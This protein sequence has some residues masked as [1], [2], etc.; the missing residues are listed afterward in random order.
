MGFKGN[1][2]N[3][4]FGLNWDMSRDDAIKLAPKSPKIK[5]L[6]S[7][8]YEVDVPNPDFNGGVYILHFDKDRLSGISAIYSE[9][10]G[11]KDRAEK[12]FDYYDSLFSLKYSKEELLELPA[13]KKRC[14]EY[15]D[16][17]ING[18]Q[19]SK[20]SFIST[21]SLRKIGDNN[22]IVNVWYGSKDFLNKI[23]ESAIK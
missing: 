9:L 16:C 8:K 23:R 5:N 1:L 6:N 21:L 14:L 11:D 7:D 10:V 12:L 3:A 18:F 22:Y 15:N 19:Y 4:P 13:S 20:D 17:R 2:T